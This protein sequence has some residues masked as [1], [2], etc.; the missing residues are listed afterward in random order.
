MKFRTAQIIQITD[1][2]YFVGHHLANRD[3][4]HNEVEH[5][6]VA[7]VMQVI[8]FVVVVRLNGSTDSHMR[9]YPM[10]SSLT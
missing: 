9:A 5:L 10:T 4:S 3:S 8:L 7:R 6:S 1:A 2:D